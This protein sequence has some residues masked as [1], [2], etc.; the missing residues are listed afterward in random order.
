MIREAWGTFARGIG[1][2]WNA[3]LNAS[4][5]ELAISVL[6]VLAILGP[7]AALLYRDALRDAR[8]SR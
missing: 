1:G 4:L 3:L 8:R 6:I 7:L 2:A 5:A